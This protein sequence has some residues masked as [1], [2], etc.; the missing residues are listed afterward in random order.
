MPTLHLLSNEGIYY[1]RRNK[2]TNK[3]KIFHFHRYMSKKSLVSSVKKLKRC[4]EY[5]TY[6]RNWVKDRIF[7]TFWDLY[8]SVLNLNSEVISLNVVFSVWSFSAVDLSKNSQNWNL[9][10]RLEI[11]F[12]FI[13]MRSRLAGKMLDESNCETLT[14]LKN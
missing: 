11:L 14:A 9:I 8:L 4:E 13:N 10:L 1:A 2:P 3:V 6:M 5:I 7:E 12:K